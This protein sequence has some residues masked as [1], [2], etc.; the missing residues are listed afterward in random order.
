MKK[1]D[2]VIRDNLKDLIETT[3]EAIE[4]G[5]EPKGGILHVDGFYIQAIFLRDTN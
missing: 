4:K 1:Y 2:I 5:Y 3:N